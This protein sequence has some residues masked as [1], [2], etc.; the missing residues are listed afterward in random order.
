M[1][2][3]VTDEGLVIGGANP[4]S[5]VPSP[6]FPTR[7]IVTPVTNPFPGPVSGPAP[8]I[9]PARLP[10]SSGADP[11]GKG[12]VPKKLLSMSVVQSPAAQQS[13]TNS[14][15][16]VSFTRD[17]S[18]VNFDHVAIWFVGYHGSST[19]TLMASGT[20]S[21]I[22]FLCDTT[23]ET[24]TV[25][26]QTISSQGLSAPLTFALSSKVTLNGIISAP[27]EPTITQYV[28]ATPT[29]FQFSFEQ[30]VLAAGDEDVIASYNVYRNTTNSTS[31]ATVIQT[32]KHN[33][34]NGG[35]PIVV[36]DT[37]TSHSGV[38]YYYWLTAVN[39]KGLESTQEACQTGSNTT[40]QP[41]VAVAN[42]VNSP[43]V[44]T[45][46]L[47]SGTTPTASY[48]AGN[49]VYTPGTFT[50]TVTTIQAG[51]N[52]VTDVLLWA[53][54]TS[55]KPNGYMFRF[56]NRSSENAGQILKVTAGAWTNIG[57]AK[58]STSAARLPVGTYN[59]FC[60]WNADGVM[61]IFV[62]GVWQFTA[63]DTTYIPTGATYYGYELNAPKIGPYVNNTS[64][65]SSGELL[66]QGSICAAGLSTFSYT[67]TTSSIT[68]TWTSFNIYNPDGSTIT[69]AANVAGTAFTGLTASTTYYFGFYVNIATGVCTVAV[70]DTSSGTAASS[71]Q[72]IVQLFQGDGNVGISWNNQAATTSSGSGGGSGG[73][74]GG[75][76]Y[77][78]T[79][80]TLIKTSH[81]D[82][83]I[84]AIKKGDLCLTAKGTW[85]PVL[86]L[87]KHK[88][89]ARMLYRLP[90]GGFVTFAHKILHDGKW[91]NAGSVYKDMC[92]SD[93]PLY[94][95]S[96]ES[97]E[98]I[99]QMLSPTT[100]RSFT[101]SN[102]IVAHN[103]QPIK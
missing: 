42:V 102:G 91:V 64:M 45:P 31:G 67:S 95:L 97:E 26:A 56:D 55:S 18:D 89:K 34:A 52:Y 2:Y 50:F 86:D 47:T 75:G 71:A 39:T 20:V 57:T 1:P 81:G 61:N 80:N 72:Q 14:A 17:T 96:M 79:G 98:T 12:G 8:I 43:A 28:V 21:P 66:S 6:I 13:Y 65:F 87:V 38:I 59:V 11:S 35:T 5:Q 58:A 49:S 84:D 54:N 100:E 46:S 77:C 29:G 27:P 92:F 101:L 74:G 36:Q 99:D 40:Y 33:P 48:T 69:V 51:T 7:P 76:H 23:D 41:I 88:V 103:V 78:F 37:V 22:E 16:Y 24:V 70:S 9:S 85:V 83:R 53:S 63:T 68:W 44:V 10:L 15:V 19:P 60:E 25:L 30:L 73:G 32:I 3:I 62:N 82:V 94:T 90:D 93:Q 4:A